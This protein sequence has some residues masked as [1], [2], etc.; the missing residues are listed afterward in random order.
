[1][2]NFDTEK[3]SKDIDKYFA[4]MVSENNQKLGGLSTNKYP[5]DSTLH[6]FIYRQ[7]TSDTDQ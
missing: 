5:Y 1:M 2:I 3:L 7:K 4:M 6:S